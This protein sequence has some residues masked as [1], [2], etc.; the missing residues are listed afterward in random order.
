MINSMTGYGESAGQIN[1]MDYIVE[2]KTVNN[3]YLRTVIKLPEAVAF[4]EERIEKLLRQNLARGTVNFVL[5]VKGLSVEELFD[6]DETALRQL[7]QR[8]DAVRSQTGA[9]SCLDVGGLLS[10]PGIVR[11]AVPTEEKT[12]QIV[13]GVLAITT[14][15]LDR[16]RAMRAAEGKFLDED[17]RTHC[18]EIRQDL[19]FIRDRRGLV[20][21]EYADRIKKRV[22]GLLA[23]AKL[24]LDEEILA[25]EVAVLAER[26]DIS[27]ELTRLDAHLSQFEQALL[28]EGE[29]VG[30]RLEF[31]GQEMLREANTIA[32]KSGD[33]EIGRRVVDIKCRVD[34]IKEQT[35]NVE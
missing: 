13:D 17:L 25:R 15:A 34:R 11:P 29:Q 9:E 1:G 5:R 32:S 4:L 16:L 35:Q 26:A 21:Q 2:L 7:I 33:V 8:L 23:E 6:L 28:L 30:R 27:E 18:H 19:Q 10:L 22:N 24:K 31:I 3:R 20:M 12:A 14:E